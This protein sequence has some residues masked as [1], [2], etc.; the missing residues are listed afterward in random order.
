MVPY[1]KG[2]FRFGVMRIEDY[3][4]VT[5]QKRCIEAYDFMSYKESKN[6]SYTTQGEFTTKYI[7]I[8]LEHI[9]R[10]Q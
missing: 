5:V 10:K 2:Q 1:I 3:F 8:I 4:G 9:K 6:T 7:E